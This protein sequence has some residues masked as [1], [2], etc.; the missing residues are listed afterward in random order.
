MCASVCV[1]LNTCM[2]IL[3]TPTTKKMFNSQLSLNL[4]I[5]IH[6]HSIALL[7]C[8]SRPLRFLLL[9]K[10][11]QE[12]IFVTLKHHILALCASAP[13]SHTGQRHNSENLQS[14]FFHKNQSSN[15]ESLRNY[16]SVFNVLQTLGLRTSHRH[17]KASHTI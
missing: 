10:R 7:P 1:L 15:L 4:S 6:S 8:E 3:E 17:A 5:I 9:S 13:S 11:K 16:T 2:S 14:Q 12:Q